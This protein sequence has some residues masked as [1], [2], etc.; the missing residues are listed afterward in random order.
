MTPETATNKPGKDECADSAE[1]AGEEHRSRPTAAA[2]GGL[3]NTAG[4]G[5]LPDVRTIE[6]FGLFALGIATA[7]TIQTPDSVLEVSRANPRQLRRALRVTLNSFDLA[8][9]KTGLLSSEVIVDAIAGDLTS[10]FKGI[11]VVDPVL[12]SSDGKQ[13]LNFQGRATLIKKLFPITSVVTPNVDEAGLFCD[14]KIDSPRDVEHVAASLL[15][16]G[17]KT[18]VV[19]CS[20]RFGGAD[21]LMTED[22]AGEWIP[23][24]TELAMQ[25]S[26]I[27]THG[28]GCFHS[29]AL[30]SLLL[31]GKNIKEAA[32]KAKLL[33]ECAILTS[34]KIKGFEA[35]LIDHF[36]LEPSVRECLRGD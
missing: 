26:E 23:A 11:L 35:R 21:Y 10:L 16:L 7:T 32:Q 6:M 25:E 20:G 9:I 31:L 4:A 27:H 8:G 18:V 24:Q 1:L 2:L 15:K 29:A 19:K 30:L 17:P 12:V 13:L 3:D 14:T 28:T 5:L 22:S 34:R 33:T 36:A